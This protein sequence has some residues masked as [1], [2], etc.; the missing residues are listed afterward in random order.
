MC[1]NP[2]DFLPKKGYSTVGT[3]ARYKQFVIDTTTVAVVTT[4]TLSRFL[5]WEFYYD[6]VTGPHIAD[7]VERKVKPFLSDNAANQRTELA[8]NAM[9]DV[10]G[11]RYRYCAANSPRLEPIEHGFSLIKKTIQANDMEAQIHLIGLLNRCFQH[12]PFQGEGGSAGNVHMLQ[13]NNYFHF[14]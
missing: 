6:S 3:P 5:A 9:E 4:Y 11:R 10:F 2:R 14:S 7:F 12:Y 13:I 8:R 1:Q